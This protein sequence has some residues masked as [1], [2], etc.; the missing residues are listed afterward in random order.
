MKEQL[1]SATI[2]RKN[3]IEINSNCYRSF[4]LNDS[5]LSTNQ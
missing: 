5:T 4:R 3:K 2:K 1:N